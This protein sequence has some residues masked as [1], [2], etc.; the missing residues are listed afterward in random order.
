L[1]VPVVLVYQREGS[2]VATEGNVH[3]HKRHVEL[4]AGRISTPRIP[5]ALEPRIKGIDLR[6]F[7]PPV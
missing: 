3:A 7:S 6:P 5:T 2:G 1:R 4:T